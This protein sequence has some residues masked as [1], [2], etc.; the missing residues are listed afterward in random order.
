MVQGCQTPMFLSFS[1][2]FHYFC[3]VLSGACSSAPDRMVTRVSFVPQYCD[4]SSRRTHCGR[5][6]S[7]GKCGRKFGELENS[8]LLMNT[9]FFIKMMIYNHNQIITIFCLGLIWISSVFITGLYVTQINGFNCN[10]DAFSMLN[11]ILRIRQSTARSQ[12]LMTQYIYYEG[13]KGFDP[14]N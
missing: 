11:V 4:N 10:K 6:Q 5:Q 9:K 8:Q 3:P 7:C 2:H 1:P 12:S 14:Q 13:M